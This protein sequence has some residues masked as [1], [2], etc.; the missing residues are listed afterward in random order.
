MTRSL[1]LTGENNFDEI[2]KFFT[3]AGPDARIRARQT[4]HGGGVEIY[5]RDLSLKG[6]LQE[7]WNTNS[8]QRKAC[9]QSAKQNIESSILNSKLAEEHNHFGSLFEAHKQDFVASEILGLQNQLSSRDE[10]SSSLDKIFPLNILLT[11]RKN[12]EPTRS[13]QKEYD[14]MAK[15]LLDANPNQLVK[16]LKKW[17]GGEFASSE[18]HQYL[19]EFNKYVAL[20]FSQTNPSNGAILID[21]VA[22]KNFLIAI[23]EIVK[24]SKRLDS[25][26]DEKKVKEMGSDFSILSEATWEALAK[27]SEELLKTSTPKEMDQDIES[28]DEK[29]GEQQDTDQ[30]AELLDSVMDTMTELNNA[31]GELPETSTPR[32]Y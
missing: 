27:W 11:V 19:A 2:T 15:N 6:R 24:S 1:V 21:F 13:N 18:L 16:V 5:I 30:T 4:A 14:D 10:I 3:E 7:W 22:A 29:D 23:N 32:S 25:G 20:N 17:S 9:Y 28:L 26:N 31:P 8:D 12:A